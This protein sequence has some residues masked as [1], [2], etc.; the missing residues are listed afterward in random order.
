MESFL[1]L[2]V[3]YSLMESLASYDYMDI[4]FLGYKEFAS[5]FFFVH[6]CTSA[7]ILSVTLILSFFVFRMFL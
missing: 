2:S 4:L 1:H 6:A 5:N 7:S 3:L